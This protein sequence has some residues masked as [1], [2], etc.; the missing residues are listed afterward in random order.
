[1]DGGLHVVGT[2]FLGA[3]HLTP[4]SLQCIRSAEKLFYLGADPATRIWLADQNPSLESLY[5]AYRPGE[6]RME[7]YERMVHRILDPVRA[8]RMVCVAFYGHPGVFVWP[9]HEAIHRARAEGF[10]ATMLPGV[11]AEDCLFADLEVDPVERGCASFEAT[12][13]LIR[14]RVFDPT[15]T[16]VLWQVGGIGVTTFS[17]DTLWNR[18]GLR[19]LAEVLQRDYPADHEVVIYEAAM[20]GFNA[21]V[22]LRVPLRALGEAQVTTSST[23]LVPPMP[24]PDFDA[25]MLRQ[26]TETPEDV[27]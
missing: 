12:D 16:L 26:I 1:V 17:R 7:S 27:P 23:L 13:F 3:G 9:S 6:S 15:T 20:F 2:G 25:A 21:P 8:G 19:V 24:Q 10:T 18:D 5:D 22:I 11:S 4:E 14:P